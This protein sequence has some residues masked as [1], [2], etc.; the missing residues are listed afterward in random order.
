M[1]ALTINYKKTCMYF[2][3]QE[4]L[5]FGSDENVWTTSKKS[6]VT[7]SLPENPVNLLISSG[8]RT[9]KPNV[10]SDVIGRKVDQ[11]GANF[12]QEVGFRT[13]A[14]KFTALWH[15]SYCTG[16]QIVV[17]CKKYEF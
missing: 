14:Y 9:A 13:Y 12:L 10:S 6:Y 1:D 3:L 5:T 16:I 4:L 15:M 7:Q 11:P 17:L 8:R 2:F